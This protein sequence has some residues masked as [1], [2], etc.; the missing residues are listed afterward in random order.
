ML[1]RHIWRW[2]TV[3]MLAAAATT[4]LAGAPASASAADVINCFRAPCDIARPAEYRTAGVS[5]KGWTYLNLNHCPQG[6][7]CRMAFRESMSAW[8]W[9]GSKWVGAT[10]KGGWVYVYPYTGNWR[11]AWTQKSGWVAV[12]SGRFEIR[13][14]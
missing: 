1:R 5:Y 7:L 2:L 12:D 8:S 10:L 3:A 9:T 14:Y 13:P 4:A 6:A 11:W